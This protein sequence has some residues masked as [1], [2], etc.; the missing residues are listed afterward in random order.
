M[1]VDWNSLVIYRDHAALLTQQDLQS[2]Q[3]PRD[4]EEVAGSRDWNDP[5]ESAYGISLSLYE[6][7]KSKQNLET[8]NGIPQLKT[9]VI[10]DPI[11]DVFAVMVRENSSVLALADGV[12]WGKNPRLAARCAVRGVMDHFAA[13]IHRLQTRSVSSR[14]VCDML[15]ECIRVAQ[16]VN[17]HRPQSN[18]YHTERGCHLSDA[19]IEQ[20]SSK[21]VGHVRDQC[22]RQ[23]CICV[24]PTNADCH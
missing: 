2:N 24:L 19:E 17:D 11:A 20:R 13:Y 10:G 7:D 3:F 12:G 4:Q 5:S 22:W 8:I 15:F 23:P 16:K 1:D 18:S 9:T 14:V 21:R 6:E